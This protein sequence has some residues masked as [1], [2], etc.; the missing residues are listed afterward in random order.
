MSGFSAFSWLSQINP[1]SWF[2]YIGNATRFSGGLSQTDWFVL[3]TTAIITAYG[4]M[5]Y[6]QT[7]YAG[8][9]G[10]R[11]AQMYQAKNYK[12]AFCSIAR[13]DIR[14][15]MS[16]SVSRINNY[17]VVATLF[18]SLAGSALFWVNNFSSN[19]PPFVVNFFWVSMVTS[20]VFLSEAIMFGIKGQ[21]SSF[22]NTMRLLTWEERP[23][24]PASYDHDYTKQILNWEKTPA[25]KGF[26]RWP[27]VPV[28]NSLGDQ[29]TAGAPVDPGSIQLEE[30]ET[31]TRDLIYL[32][33]F[34]HF[35]RL[36]VP[37]EIYAKYTIGLG[38][39]NLAQ[40]AAYF[41]LGSLS[42]SQS[43]IFREV[44]ACCMI[45]MFVFL[46]VMIYSENYVAKSTY[47]QVAVI[48]LSCGAPSLRPWRS[49]WAKS[50]G[51]EL[52]SSASP[53]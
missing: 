42:W 28:I 22:I 2:D 39:L 14:Q 5:M 23:E 19:C 35:M 31:P 48:T 10:L 4:P 53:A 45:S 6:N 32:A 43:S 29:G 46:T 12:L 52:C 13:G 21:N 25:N 11:Q 8:V 44:L 36:W 34:A 26:W 20:I 17:M 3:P 18:L 41:S 37:F 30:L 15:L 9:V 16:I 24:N 50:R 7:A 33:R 51:Y 38:L 27:K 40:G 47:L 49:S 1:Q